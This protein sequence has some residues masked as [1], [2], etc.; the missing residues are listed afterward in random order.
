MA[1]LAIALIAALAWPITALVRL[2]YKVEFPLT[3]R[4]LLAYRLS[5]IFAW[6]VIAAVAGW[7]GLIAAFTND[8][9]SVGGPLDWLINLLRTITPIASIGLLIASTWH[10]LLSIQ[11]NR[12]WTTKL[13]AIF[14]I[15]AGL[16]LTWIALQFHLYGYNMV[17]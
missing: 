1:A 17:Y 4:S 5:R 6:L 12:H 13:G 8:L 2:R 15:F 14:M 10:L 9:G 16:V 3:R 11:N 7:A